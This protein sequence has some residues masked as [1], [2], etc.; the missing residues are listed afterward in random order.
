MNNLKFRS[1]IRVLD[2]L[3]DEDFAYVACA[4][5]YVIVQLDIF[6]FRVIDVIRSNPKLLQWR[7]ESSGNGYLH[8]MAYSNMVEQTML[9]LKLGTNCCLKNKVGLWLVM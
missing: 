6:Y 7:D 1:A 4:L 9:M 2:A 5:I 3:Y 8:F